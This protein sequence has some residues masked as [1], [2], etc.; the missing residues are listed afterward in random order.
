VAGAHLGGGGAESE[1]VREGNSSP[2]VCCHWMPMSGIRA[3]YDRGAVKF[4]T[5]EDTNPGGGSR[6]DGASTAAL[7]RGRDRVD[8]WTFFNFHICTRKN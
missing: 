7:A 4:I 6:F 8:R 3:H 2:A 5:V 1:R